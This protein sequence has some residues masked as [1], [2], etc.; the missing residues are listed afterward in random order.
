MKKILKWGGIVLLVIVIIGAIGSSGS[1][2]PKKVDTADTG[3][4]D[5][6]S[7]STKSETKVFKIGESVNLD[8]KL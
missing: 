7:D 6:R 4:V 2:E 3:I 8:G 1:N 5:N